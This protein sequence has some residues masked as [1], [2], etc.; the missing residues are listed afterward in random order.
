[1]QKES[2]RNSG[3]GKQPNDKSEKRNEEPKEKRIDIQPMH[4]WSNYIQLFTVVAPISAY[5]RIAKKFIEGRRL[6]SP[7][8]HNRTVYYIAVLKVLNVLMFVEKNL[9]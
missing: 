3:G 7:L 8:R 4:V 5:E 1:M 6:I 9:F 2:E